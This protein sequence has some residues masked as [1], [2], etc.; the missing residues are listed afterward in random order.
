M[1]NRLLG[2]LFCNCFLHMFLALIFQCL[3]TFTTMEI[4]F[5]IWFCFVLSEFSE[6]GGVPSQQINQHIHENLHS[7][8]NSHNEFIDLLSAIRLLPVI[9]RVSKFHTIS[10]MFLVHVLITEV[11]MSFYSLKFSLIPCNF[12]ID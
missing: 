11:L 9:E 8:T 1:A 12:F 3:F 6:R 5:C 4:C 10:M 7:C 2:F